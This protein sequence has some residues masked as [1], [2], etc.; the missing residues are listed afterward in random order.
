MIWDVAASGS[1]LTANGGSP[2]RGIPLQAKR[3]RM[4][5]GVRLSF[6]IF[7]LARGRIA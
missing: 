4:A 5:A 2:F 3:T 1:Y 7:L 6:G